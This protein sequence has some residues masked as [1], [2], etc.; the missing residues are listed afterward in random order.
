LFYSI[1]I[2]KTSRTEIERN[3]YRVVFF[4]V[5]IAL[6]IVILC[7][8]EK[9]YGDYVHYVNAKFINPTA[10]AVSDT[11]ESRERERL[12]NQFREMNAKGLCIP[13]DY[14]E[15]KVALTNFVLV[16]TDFG[17]AFGEGRPDPSNPKSYLKGRSCTD[18]KETFLLTEWGS[19]YWVIQ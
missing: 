16:E 1:T 14:G 11:L 7:V 5:S 17:L 3:I 4:L 8:A 18:G 19:W 2:R 9:S 6:Y 13:A 15:S 10:Q 12:L